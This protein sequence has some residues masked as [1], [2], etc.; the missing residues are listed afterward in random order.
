MNTSG[1]AFIRDSEK[2]RNPVLGDK[3]NFLVL[4]YIHSFLRWYEFF[5]FMWFPLYLSLSD[6]L[7]PPASLLSW[8]KKEERMSISISI[9]FFIPSCLYL[10]FFLFY[11]SV[12]WQMFCFAVL[13]LF[14]SFSHCL[15]FLGRLD[16]GGGGLREIFVM[17]SFI[18]A[19]PLRLQVATD[20]ISLV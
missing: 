8:L 13:S 11:L 20:C 12:L 5:S 3:H 18:S 7:P 17:F 2:L 1:E 4:L 9:F 15:F 16:N 10:F 14:L 6:S 19:C